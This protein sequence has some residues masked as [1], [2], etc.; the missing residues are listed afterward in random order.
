MN[1]LERTAAQCAWA[2]WAVGEKVL[3]FGGLLIAAIILPPWPAA[4]LICAVVAAALVAARVRLRVVAL[5]L[6]GP[7]VFIALG[8]A[9]VSLDL[10]GALHGGPWFPQVALQRAADTALRAL[11]ASAATVA[12]ACTT[13]MAS[14]LAAARALGLPAP[15]CHL[16]DTTYR[17]VG[18]LI[19]TARALGET[20]A[21]R[22]GFAQRRRAIAALGSQFATV[23]VQALSRSRRMDEAMSLR[24]APGATA[25]TPRRA[26]ASAARLAGIVAILAGTV[27]ISLGLSQAMPILLTP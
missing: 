2:Q 18:I 25:V 7:A 19:A 20:I 14:L 15:L 22:L 17:L 3:L 11:S 8:A 5:A 13:T 26:P 9:A 27:G 4:P 12:L 24:A 23:F 21:L 16:T 6:A 10:G 1:P